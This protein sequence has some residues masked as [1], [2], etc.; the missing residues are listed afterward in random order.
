MI[1]DPAG[2]ASGIRLQSLRPRFHSLRFFGLP[3]GVGTSDT[4]GHPRRPT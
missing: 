1:A 2:G 4:G 3:R